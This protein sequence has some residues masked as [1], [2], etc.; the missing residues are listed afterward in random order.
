MKLMTAINVRLPHARSRCAP[1]DSHTRVPAD[2]QS[3]NPH[4]ARRSTVNIRYA[5]ARTPLL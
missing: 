5:A 1:R 4:R 3:S 2:P